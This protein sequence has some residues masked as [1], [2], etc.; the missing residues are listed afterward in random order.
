M[1]SPLQDPA[2]IQFSSY[3]EDICT[4]GAFPL[5]LLIFFNLRMILRIRASTSA[6]FSANR[7]VG[8]RES[9]APP[10]GAVRVPS[11]KKNRDELYKNRSSWKIDSRRLFSREY[12]FPKTFA[13]TEN[14]FSGKTYFYTIAYR[15][16]SSLLFSRKSSN[17]KDKNIGR[18]M[19]CRSGEICSYS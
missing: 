1:F 8:R 5:L 4:T 16:K 15:K 3:W 2:Y 10:S 17:Y 12:D 18:K 11:T 14:P 7:F 6:K 13:L 19:S 9:V